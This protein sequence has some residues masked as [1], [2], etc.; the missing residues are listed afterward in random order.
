MP[1]R[2]WAQPVP[3]LSRLSPVGPFLSR[4]SAISPLRLRS[5]LSLDDLGDLHFQLDHGF[6]SPGVFW[7]II[8][9]SARHTEYETLFNSG[10]LFKNLTKIP[11]ISNESKIIR[12]T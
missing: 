3:G 5:P 9:Q 1:G 2:E 7:N 4:R 6:T 8:H 11:D 10:N 12:I